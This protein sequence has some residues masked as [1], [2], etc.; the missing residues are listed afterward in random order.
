M[1]WPLPPKRAPLRTII[2]FIMFHSLSL[3]LSAIPLWILRVVSNLY[4]DIG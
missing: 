2:Q 1:V 3:T 4:L